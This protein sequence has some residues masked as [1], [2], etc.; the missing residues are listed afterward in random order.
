M[1]AA[2][3]IFRGIIDPANV[4]TGHRF[5]GGYIGTNANRDA[6]LKSKTD[7]WARQLHCMSCL[8]YTSDAADE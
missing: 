7:E 2:R 5:L 6:W 1:E 3:A 4:V 8:L